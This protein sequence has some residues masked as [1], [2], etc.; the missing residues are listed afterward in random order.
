MWN[1]AQGRGAHE[2]ILLHLSKGWGVSVR[3]GRAGSQPH[4]GTERLPCLQ[5]TDEAHFIL[6]IGGPLIP[7]PRDKVS[8][9]LG[10][11]QGVAWCSGAT[12]QQPVLLLHPEGLM[13][14]RDAHLGRGTCEPHLLAGWGLLPVFQP[15]R[16][17]GAVFPAMG[18]TV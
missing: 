3:P 16:Q 14:W 9:D 10:G 12:D 5:G 13:A 17:G 15:G 11:A 1:G 8:G 7:L 18:S 4:M 6:S 2:R